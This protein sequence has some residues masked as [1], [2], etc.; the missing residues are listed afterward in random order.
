MTELISRGTSPDFFHVSVETLSRHREYLIHNPET[1]FRDLVPKYLSNTLK[2]QIAKAQ[3][4]LNSEETL[5][6]ET[7]IIHVQPDQ[8]LEM[9]EMLRTSLNLP[10]HQEA[11]ST[12]AC[13]DLL[14]CKK[15]AADVVDFELEELLMNFKYSRALQSSPPSST[16][17]RIQM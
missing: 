5:S 13:L 16:G 15:T 2:S 8:T 6:T 17:H 7:G 9:K 14:A 3:Q 10:S 4:L 11:A 12:L 1:Q